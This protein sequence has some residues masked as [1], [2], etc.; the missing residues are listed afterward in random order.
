[1]WATIVLGR[2]S[3][4]GLKSMDVGSLVEFRLHGDRQLG[5]VIGPEGK[6]KWNLQVPTGHVHTVHPRQVSFVVPGGTFPVGKILP[7]DSQVAR[8]VTEGDLELAWELLQESDDLI[9]PQILAGLLF[10]EQSAETCYAAHVLLS[11]DRLYFKQRAEGYEPR[12]LSQ[13]EEIRHQLEMAERKQRQQ[14]QFM[15]RI[16][17]HILGQPQPWQEGDRHRLELI[18]RFALWQD[19]SKDKSQAQDLLRTLGYKEDAA[20]AQQ[21][22]VSLGWWGPY[23]NLFLRRSGVPVQFTPTLLAQAQQLIT[24]PPADTVPRT[25]LHRLAAYTIDDPT[26]QEIDDALSLEKLPDGTERLWVHIADPTRWVQVGSPL[27][28]EARRRATSIYLP[29]I[30]IPMFPSLLATGP[31]SLLAGRDNCALSF[32]VQ[33]GPEGEIVTTEIVTTTLDTVYRLDYQEVDQLLET[34]VEPVLARLW[35]LAQLRRRYRLGL[36]GVQIDMPE[37][38]VKAKDQ[39]EDLSLEVL[40][41]SPARALVSEMM[42]LVGEVAARYAQAHDLSLPHRV[43]PTPTL[44]AP[45]ELERLPWGPVRDYAICRCMQRGELRVE[46]G[47]HGGLGLEGYAQATSPIRRYSDLLVHYQLKAHLHGQPI[48]YT[49]QALRELLMT[50][51]AAISDSVFLERQSVR[52][53]VLEYLR[54]HRDQPQPALVLDWTGGDPQRPLVLLENS[55]L[56]LP[57]RLDRPVER[58]DMLDLAI[59]QI[60]PSRDY[61]ILK[62]VR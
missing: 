49:A 17:S 5:V 43:Q 28:E 4:V 53:W 30:T 9:T 39:G 40:T 1:M 34:G 47:R 45:E 7:F 32:A 29:E 22:L 51:E 62:E 2:R 14:Q 36:G 24:D 37:A 26:T 10:N 57:V 44:P 18:E 27:E 11:N 59:T 41:D 33:L 6:G 58:G 55:A 61:L 38:V 20:A 19:E 21:L 42:I 52:Y 16:Q 60:D 8:L 25:R 46:P 56:R 50:L 15:E 31:L 12:P 48:P 54:R 13:V 3:Q 35:T 23:E